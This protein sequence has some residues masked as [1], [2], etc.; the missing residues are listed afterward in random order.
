MGTAGVG[1]WNRRRAEVDQVANKWLISGKAPLNIQE[2]FAVSVQYWERTRV[3]YNAVLAILVLICWGGDLLSNRSPSIMGWIL[4]P[5]I[6]T[7]FA[8]IANVL[9]CAAYPLDVVLQ[10]TPLRSYWLR[11]RWVMF[12]GGTSL[13]SVLAVWVLLGDGMG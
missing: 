11:F 8:T 12:I 6:L 13:A 9:Y 3:I 5:L 10:S 2:R 7:L 4:L 1:E